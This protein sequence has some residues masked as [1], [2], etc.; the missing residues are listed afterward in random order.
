M[1]DSRR[2]GTNVSHITSPVTNDDKTVRDSEQPRVN[3]SQPSNEAASE[4]RRRLCLVS[5]KR[6]ARAIRQSMN[7]V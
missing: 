5:I 2:P 7:F 6:S 3:G 1:N 4:I